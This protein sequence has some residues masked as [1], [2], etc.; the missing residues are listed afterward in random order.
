MTRLFLALGFGLRS[1]KCRLFDCGCSLAR[2]TFA[3]DDIL[4][5]CG[6][7]VVVRAARVCRRAGEGF[8]LNLVFEVEAYFGVGGGAG[9]F[10]G[11]EG[12]CSVFC[13]EG[14]DGF[15]EPGFPAGD[16]L[17]DVGVEAGGTGEVEGLAVECVGALKG[18]VGPGDAEVE[19]GD[20]EF[21]GG[22]DEGA[23]HVGGDVG[24]GGLGLS[25]ILILGCGVG[26]G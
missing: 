1:A 3:Q 24:D 15:E 17:R 22:E 7:I 19:G 14:V 20:G 21:A 9:D 10:D 23:T 26:W 25:L 12:A 18:D 8:T 2:T 4:Y 5:F 6:W 11:D 16:H 13:E